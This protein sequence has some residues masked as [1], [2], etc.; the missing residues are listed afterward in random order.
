MSVRE[1]KIDDVNNGNFENLEGPSPETKKP[2]ATR[3]S[4]TCL[5][6]SDTGAPDSIFRSMSRFSPRPLDRISHLL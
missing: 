1:R 2:P 3:T 5:R 4:R 6:Q